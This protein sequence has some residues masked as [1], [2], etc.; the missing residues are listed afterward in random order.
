MRFYIDCVLW[1]LFRHSIQDAVKL[2]CYS[3]FQFLKTLTF[4]IFRFLTTE[5]YFSSQV[6]SQIACFDHCSTLDSRC[7]HSFTFAS[8]SSFNTLTFSF[9]ALLTTGL[10]RSSW[11]PSQTVTSGHCS[12]TLFRRLGRM[13][14]MSRRKYSLRGSTMVG[15]PSKSI[16]KYLMKGGEGWLEKERWWLGARREMKDR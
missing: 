10:Y 4:K 16:T 6:S 9:L 1:P 2:Y 3:I 5:L 14:S 7:Y 13:M 15:G 11:G 8:S 12:D